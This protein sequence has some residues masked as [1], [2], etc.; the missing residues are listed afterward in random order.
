MLQEH[1]RVLVLHSSRFGQ[2]I[3]IADAISRELVARGAVTELAPLTLATSP[4]PARYD[5]FALVA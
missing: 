4:N 3:K 2:S 5:A 1:P